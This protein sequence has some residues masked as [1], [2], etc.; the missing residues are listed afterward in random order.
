MKKLNC[1]LSI[2]L[3]ESSYATWYEIIRWTV[4]SSVL[5][6]VGNIWYHFSG[7]ITCDHGRTHICP[8]SNGAVLEQGSCD[9]SLGRHSVNTFNR[10]S[11]CKRRIET[12]S[13][14]EL[15]RVETSPWAWSIFKPGFIAAEGIDF[16][17]L[18]AQTNGSAS[19]EMERICGE[20]R[21]GVG[22]RCNHNGSVAAE[23]SSER[24]Q[25]AGKKIINSRI[26][27][28]NPEPRL[29]C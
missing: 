29:G 15:R 28:L 1:V 20:P 19:S 9:W 23:R 2:M 3:P 27:V 5:S 25:T 24:I 13:S 7:C 14:N 18:E 11:G 16:D 10:S 21:T 17:E 4:F 22:L 8:R 6:V 12:G 26:T